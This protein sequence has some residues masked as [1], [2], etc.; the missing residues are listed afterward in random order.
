MR[1]PDRK[2]LFLVRHGTAWSNYW[3]KKLGPDDW[4]KVVS[5]CS[6]IAPTNKTYD[7]FDAGL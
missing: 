5:T 4:F 2:L 6:Y 7:I 3:Q 1:A